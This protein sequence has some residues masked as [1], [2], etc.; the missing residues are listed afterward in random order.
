MGCEVI[1]DSECLEGNEK[2]GNDMRVETI[3]GRKPCAE[4]KVVEICQID[5]MARLLVPQ[6]FRGQYEAEKNIDREH[7]NKIRNIVTKRRL[8]LSYT[9]VA[10]PFG[11]L[12]HRQQF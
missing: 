1:T 6:Q 4:R 8:S 3:L 5:L 12:L 10:N 7:E 2:Q 9:V 11:G